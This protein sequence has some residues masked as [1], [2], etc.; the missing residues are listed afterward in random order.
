MFHT[1]LF[2]DFPLIARS[3][4]SNF[5]IMLIGCAPHTWTIG[6]W[7]GRGGIFSRG[8]TKGFFQNFSKEGT[9]VLK[10]VFFPLETKKITF[11]C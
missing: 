5:T 9:K 4:K 2:S 11:F 6:P 10:F 1:Y 8:D 7:H 3:G